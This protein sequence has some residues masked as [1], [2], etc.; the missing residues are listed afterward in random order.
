MKMKI[1]IDKAQ[2]RNDG[3][4]KGSALSVT[5]SDLDF[6][7]LC[8]MINALLLSNST[9]PGTEFFTWPR[10]H[11]KEFLGASKMKLVF[12]P[13]AAVTLSYEEYAEKVKEVFNAIGYEVESLHHSQDKQKTIRNADGFVVGG[14]NSFALLHWIYKFDLLDTIRQRVLEGIPYIGWSAGGNLACPT[15]MT[16]NDMPIVQL[17]SLNALNLVPFQIN[18]HYHELKFEGQG[19]ETR[20]ERLEEFIAFNP[21]KKIIG[22]P[23]GMLLERKGNSLILKGEFDR[24]AKLYIH[25]KPVEEFRAETDL[26]NLLR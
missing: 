7:Y 16:T 4:K 13:F 20:K 5:T 19:G 21:T 17:P 3:I 2:P 9:L 15:I 23:E 22:L 12:I 11:V 6:F 24:I 14:G 1:F 26:S 25:G 18:P 8:S 10:S